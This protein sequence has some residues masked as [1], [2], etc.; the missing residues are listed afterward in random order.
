MLPNAVIQQHLFRRVR[1]VI[2]ATND[3]RDLHTDVVD[4]DREVVGRLPVRSQDDE[5][6]DVGVVERNR[7][8]HEIVEG[9]LAFRHAEPD[10]ARRVLPRRARRRSSAGQRRR[11]VRSYVHAGSSARL[12]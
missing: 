6:L 12:R 9:R 1:N 7:A 2:V 8:A 5:I 10:R 11:H 4:D 3:V